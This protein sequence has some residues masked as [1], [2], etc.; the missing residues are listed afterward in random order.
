MGAATPQI[1]YTASKGA[2]LAMTREIAVI[3]ARQGIRANALCPGP[4]LTPLLAK[5]L[6]DDAKRQRRLVHIPMGRF[7]EPIEIA[8]GAL[9]L[10]SDE[11]SFMTGQS[12]LIDGGITAAY[13]TPRVTVA[14]NRTVPLDQLARRTVGTGDIDTVLVVFPDLQGRLARQAR[15]RRVL[16]RHRARRR[17]R[18][19]RLPARLRPRQHAAAG[20]PLR[21]AT[22]RATAT[23]RGVVDRTTIRYLPWLENTALVVCDLVDVDTG[24]PDRGVAARGCCGARWT[25]ATDAGYVPMFGSEIEFFLFKETYDEAHAKGYRDADA[26]LA[27]PRG[28]PHPADDQGR[29]R[30]RRDPSRPRRRPGVPVE[31][32][33]GEAGRGQHEINLDYPRPSRWPT[34]T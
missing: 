20:L 8:N 11:S 24:V 4:V 13:T 32:S 28:L 3:Y 6:S 23:C 1:A 34:A 9:F 7:G 12:L 2:V 18:E 25:R 27:V 29:V 22:S 10:A 15:R 30:H 14:T 17:H 5:F 19:L 31:F 21:R 16:P 33:K 26:A